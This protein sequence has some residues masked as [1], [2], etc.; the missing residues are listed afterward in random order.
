MSDHHWGHDL[1]QERLTLKHSS[2]AYD[3]YVAPNDQKYPFSLPNP[4]CIQALEVW[5]ISFCISLQ[6]AID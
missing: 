4:T 3:A 1:I 6:R 2:G 5:L